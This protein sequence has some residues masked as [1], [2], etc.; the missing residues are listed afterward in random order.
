MEVFKFKSFP[1][2]RP[3]ICDVYD[4]PHVCHKNST[5]TLSNGPWPIRSTSLAA[6]TLLQNSTLQD[7]VSWKRVF[8]YIYSQPL[9]SLVSYFSVMHISELPP[10]A[11][12]KVIFRI[13]LVSSSKNFIFF[14]ETYKSKDPTCMWLKFFS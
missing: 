3:C 7:P 12:R 8:H 1:G 9:L 13:L 14:G 2:G 10:Y 11:L 6:R 4:Y 5:I